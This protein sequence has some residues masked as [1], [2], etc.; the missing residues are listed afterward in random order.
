MLS[1]KNIKTERPSKKLDHTN[2]GPYPIKHVVHG[3]R[4]YE[5]DLPANLP[6][7]PVFH[8]SLL[9]AMPDSE[10]NPPYPGQHLEP[11]P[12]MVVLREGDEEP[13]QEWDVEAILSSAWKNTRGRVAKG[14]KRKMELW[15][16]VQWVGYDNASWHHVKDLTN[17]EEKIALYHWLHPTADGPVRGFKKPPGW[18]PPTTHERS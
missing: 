3:G 4:A 13:Q 6:I 8:P 18:E 16:Y 17:C 7:H 12:P 5:L 9:T 10:K 15:Y 11:P 1:A 2:F 14:Q